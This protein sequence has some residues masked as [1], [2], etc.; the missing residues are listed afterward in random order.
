MTAHIVV[1][2]PRF[3]A[4]AATCALVALAA[5][6]GRASAAGIV[7]QSYTPGGASA[8]FFI[9][10]GQSIGQT[11]TAGITGTLTGVDVEIQSFGGA[12]SQS[13]SLE[14]VGV[15]GGAPNTSD[16]LATATIPP[17]DIPSSAGFVHVDL[18]AGT[19]V[20]SGTQYAIFLSTTAPSCCSGNWATDSQA[21]YSGGA[22]GVINPSWADLSNDMGFITYVQP[23]TTGS[24]GSP[25]G[26]YCSVAGN[27][28]D[29]GLTLFPGTFL[30][31]DDGQANSDPHYAGAKP[32]NFIEGTGLTCAAPPAGYSQHGYATADMNVDAGIYPYYSS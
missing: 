9:E 18:G 8:S 15:A 14:I 11:F 32:A 27:T 4:V 16:V 7:D 13:V 3:F 24:A 30:N 26:A 28:S 10:S 19:S 1:D 6:A 20:T 31:L 29:A 17:V 21:G 23:S 2:K 25:R 5:F 22:E 12:P